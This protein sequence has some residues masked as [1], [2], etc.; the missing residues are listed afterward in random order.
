MSASA[1]AAAPFSRAVVS[2]M[3]KLYVLMLHSFE[4]RMGAYDCIGIQSN[5]RIKVG[6]ILAVCE[7]PTH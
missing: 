5:W 4:M 3:R 2:A 1:A 6:T 7:R